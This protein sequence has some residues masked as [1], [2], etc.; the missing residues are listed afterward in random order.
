MPLA[1]TD[2]GDRDRTSLKETFFVWG[3]YNAARGLIS[4]CTIAEKS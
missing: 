3:G 2:S 4:K 1:T